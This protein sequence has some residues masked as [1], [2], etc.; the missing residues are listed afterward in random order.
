MKYM[1]NEH[2][3]HVGYNTVTIFIRL[4]VVDSQICEIPRNS[5][6]IRTYSSSRL[7]KVVDLGVN[8]KHIYNFLLVINSNSH[9]FRDIQS[10]YLLT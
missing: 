8:R 2:K 3:E 7:S 4:A 10:P 1:T 9:S 5:T 6:N